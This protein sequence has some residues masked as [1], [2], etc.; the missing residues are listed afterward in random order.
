MSMFSGV[1]ALCKFGHFKIVRIGAQ[2]KKKKKKK[3]NKMTNASAQSDQ[4]SLCTL[5]V[6][7]DLNFLHADSK[8]F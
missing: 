5:R 3:I 7:K 1:I 6:A 4:S 2:K 8:D